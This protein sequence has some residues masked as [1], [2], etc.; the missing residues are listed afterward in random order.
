MKPSRTDL[1]NEHSFLDGG[2]D[3]HAR[4]V[5]GSLI[6]AD[7]REQFHVLWTNMVAFAMENPE[8][9]VFF[10]ARHRAPDLDEKSR[11]LASI[12]EQMNELI[13]Q[14]SKR[15]VT[16][17]MPPELLLAVVFGMKTGVTKEAQNGRLKLSPEILS[18][19][20]ACCWDAIRRI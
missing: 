1:A 15:G 20:E 16:K 17:D 5:P 12:R 8:A 9:V 11:E 6:D 10:E 4:L 14:I 18:Q 19:A 13:R 7:V 2:S 3:N